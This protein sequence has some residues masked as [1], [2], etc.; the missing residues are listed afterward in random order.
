MREGEGGCKGLKFFE[1]IELEMAE[2]DNYLCMFP[3]EIREVLILKY[4]EGLT[5]VQVADLTGYAESTCKAWCL[6]AL[7]QNRW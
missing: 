2:V 3:R 6:K 1:T 7:S 5:Y 4:I